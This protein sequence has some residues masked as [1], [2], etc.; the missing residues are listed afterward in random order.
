MVDACQIP[1]DILENV[2][3]KQLAEICFNYPLFHDYTSVND[4]RKGIS[5]MIEMF[6]GLKELSKRKDG[7]QELVYIYERYPVL[8]E[9]PKE[10][11]KDYFMPI[12][13]PFLELLQSDDNFIKQLDDQALTSLGKIVL[14]K[15]ERKLENSHIY[16]LHN[17]SKTFLLGA[18]ILLNQNIKSLSP[19]QKAIVKRYIDNCS[20]HEPALFTEISKLLSELL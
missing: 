20:N 11:S 8:S 13:L 4:Q 19:E 9:I 2:N 17:I 12:K 14:D 3:D 18:V 16:S 6:N 15:Y 1:S 5:R 10:D 7:A